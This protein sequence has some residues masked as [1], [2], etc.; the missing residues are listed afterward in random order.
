MKRDRCCLTSLGMVNALGA[1]SSEIYA[2]ALRGCRDGITFRDDLIPGEAVPV[3]SVTAELPP[4][5]EHLHRYDCRNNRLLLA[6]YTQIALQVEDAVSRFGCG[7][8]GLIMGSSTSGMSEG[9]EALAIRIA[10]GAFPATFSTAQ[11]EYGSVSEFLAAYTGITGPAYTVSTACSSSAR[12]FLSGRNLLDMDICDAVVVGGVD[13]LCKLTLNG[14]YDLGII[15][16]T[17]C[18][19]MSRN[20][21][22]T[23]IGEGAAVFLMARFG[24]N[25]ELLGVGESSDAFNISA[26]DPDGAGAD[27][28]IR[29]ALADAGL[30][31]EDISYINLHG[32][33]TP[34]NDEMESRVISRL[35]GS[36][37]PCSST[38]P[39]TGHTL[40]AAGAIEL[41]F[42]WLALQQPRATLPPHCWDGEPDPALPTLNLVQQGTVVRAAKP[43]A[44]LSN[45]FAFGGSNCAVIIGRNTD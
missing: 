2:K 4:I 40:G 36:A 35:F 30:Q 12:V 8:V 42:C 43:R 20:R 23:V 26:P 14:F 38:K 15:S 18:N 24:S 37:A 16:E 28:A 27:A 21:N 5:P 34:Q 11:Q 31:S 1:H 10:N 33:G 13:S 9:E 45:S 19:P 3:A 25:T 7:R 6:A 17:A 32:T 39:L 44:F 41:A 29:Q 22:G